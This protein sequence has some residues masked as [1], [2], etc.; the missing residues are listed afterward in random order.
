MFIVCK[1]CEIGCRQDVLFSLLLVGGSDELPR[2]KRKMCHLNFRVDGRLLPASSA[3]EF[4]VV[5]VVVF[6][7]SLHADVAAWLLPAFH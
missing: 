2:M 4:V 5:V 3:G 7:P 6:L 1:R